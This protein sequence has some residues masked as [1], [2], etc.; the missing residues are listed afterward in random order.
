MRVRTLVS[1][2]RIDATGHHLLLVV[3]ETPNGPRSV[4]VDAW[5]SP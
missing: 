2:N 4:A 5:S 1:A 3:Q